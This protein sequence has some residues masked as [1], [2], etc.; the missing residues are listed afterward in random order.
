MNKI[1]EGQWCHPDYILCVFIAVS[2][3]VWIYVFLYKKLDPLISTFTQ[4]C[5]DR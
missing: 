5:V 1:A 4:E 3:M 2:Y